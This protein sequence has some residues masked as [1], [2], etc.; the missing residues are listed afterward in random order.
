MK[1]ILQKRAIFNIL[2]DDQK[3]SSSTNRTTES[4]PTPTTFIS[5]RHQSSFELILEKIYAA[6]NIKMPSS[7][8]IGTFIS[9][10]RI[11]L[12]Q[13]EDNRIKLIQA[14]GIVASN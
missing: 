13:I 3:E 2:M 7:P 10:E 1:L 5:K 8:R 14:G 11:K 4:E 12:T 6:V 9:N